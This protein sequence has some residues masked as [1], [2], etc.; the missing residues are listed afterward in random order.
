MADTEFFMIMPRPQINL[1]SLVTVL[2]CCTLIFSSCSKSTPVETVN[3]STS[4]IKAIAT[5]KLGGVVVAGA[6]KKLTISVSGVGGVQIAKDVPVSTIGAG[7][8]MDA[9]GI[10]PASMI[11]T[12]GITVPGDSILYNGITVT[13][14][15]FIVTHGDLLNSIKLYGNLAY[16]TVTF[17]D[18]TSPMIT[19]LRIPFFLYYKATEPS[20]S[21]LAAHAADLFGIGPGYSNGSKSIASPLSYLPITGGQI[22]GFKLSLVNFNSNTSQA[23]LLTVGLIPSNLEASAGFNL[24]PLSPLT[25]GGYANYITGTIVYNGITVIGPMAFSTAY[26]SASVI[27]DT[28]STGTSYSSLAANSSVRIVTNNGFNYLYTVSSAANAT[29]IENPTSS[30]ENRSIFGIDFFVN[31]EFLVD[32]TNHQI[33]LKSN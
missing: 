18:A 7:V 15:T 14:K 6:T 23:A 32:Y 19:T 24:H 9:Q 16:A 29:V 33:G 26:T 3:G 4:T 25:G 28:K 1:P 8:E 12:S 22:S 5:I 10:L 11:T 13:N 2:I 17:G 27:Q 31:N 30:G 21:Q 20:G